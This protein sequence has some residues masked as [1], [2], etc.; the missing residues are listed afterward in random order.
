MNSQLSTLNFQLSTLI[1]LC[2]VFFA[3]T[4]H[5]AC[6]LDMPASTP[7]SQLI[8]N[9][10]GTITDSKTGLM[11][12]QC[13]EGHSLPGCTGTAGSFTWQQALQQ[14]G[15]VNATGFAG[16]TD[17]RLPNLKELRSIVEEQ[18]YSPAINATRFPNTPSSLVWSGSPYANGSDGAWYV[19]YNYGVSGSGNR[20]Y[21]YAVRLVRGGQ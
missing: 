6:N 2:C 18:C 11:W 17:W 5:A 15:V 13:V 19:G 20:G 7:D 4:V 1:I 10:D 8:D 21:N 9:G 12:K 16:Y 3:A 14:P